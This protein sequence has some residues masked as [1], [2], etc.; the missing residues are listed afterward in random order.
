MNEVGEPLHR[1]DGSLRQYAVPQVEDVAAPSL[2]AIENFASFLLNH[3][4]WRQEESRVKKLSF[5]GLLLA[6]IR[7]RMK[8]D[9]ER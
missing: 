9:S 1:V 4:P 3:R 6:Y 8:R 5:E 7:D 2:H